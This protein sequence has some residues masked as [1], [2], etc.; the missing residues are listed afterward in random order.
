[1]LRRPVWI[2]RI[3]LRSGGGLHLVRFLNRRFPRR[4]L[5]G[6]VSQVVSTLAGRRAR[7]IGHTLQRAALLR[8]ACL[9]TICLRS[10]RALLRGRA[11]GQR[12]APVLL[13][14]AHCQPRQGNCCYETPRPLLSDQSSSTPFPGL[15]MIPDP[16]SRRR[17]SYS[18]QR[19]SHELLP[20]GLHQEI[21]F[22][23]LSP[24]SHPSTSACRIDARTRCPA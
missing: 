16:V 15:S 21:R 22:I 6:Q 9:G 23:R 5:P 8:S 18:P 17:S 3:C 2:R 19:R 14:R 11:I 24:A 4:H 10:R 20:V 7:R 12:T 1:L 13:C